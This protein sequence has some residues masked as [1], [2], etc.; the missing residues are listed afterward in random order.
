MLT[1]RS[2][3]C[4]LLA[5]TVAVLFLAAPGCNDPAGPSTGA[6]NGPAAHD[7][8]GHDNGQAHATPG[9]ASVQPATAKQTLCPVMG[10]E[11]DAT[12]SVVHEGRKVFF[13]C[14]DCI[15]TFKKD[16]AKYLAKL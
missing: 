5:V 12:V 7:H 8:S 6:Q 10:E 4:G 11:I 16:P 9:S 1:A 14:E 3:V 2:T 15:D 13:C